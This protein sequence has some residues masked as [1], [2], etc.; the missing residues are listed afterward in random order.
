MASDPSKRPTM[1]VAV[2]RFEKIVEA[3]TDLKSASGIASKL[4]DDPNESG[5]KTYP[6]QG[7]VQEQPAKQSTEQSTEQPAEQPTEQFNEQSNKQPNE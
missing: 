6:V 4:R 7:T 1:D 5:E 3:Q 2:E